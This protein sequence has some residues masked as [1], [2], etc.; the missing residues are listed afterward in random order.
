MLN[1]TSDNLFLALIASWNAGDRFVV[2]YALKQKQVTGSLTMWQLL[3]L[4]NLG[5]KNEL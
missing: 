1:P 2:K 5:N 3:V 4:Q